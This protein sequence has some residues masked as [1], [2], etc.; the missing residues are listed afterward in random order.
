MFGTRLNYD[1]HFFVDGEEISGVNSVDIGYRNSANLSKPLGYLGG[2]TTVGGPTEQS[3]SVSRYLISD[4]TI[5]D[6]TIGQ[7]A[8]GSL[9]YNNSSYGFTNGY[10]TNYSVNVAVG[11]IPQVNYNFVIYDELRSGANASGT[12]T[13]NIDIPTQ[14]SITA[15]CNNSTTNRVLGFDYS[16]TY[17]IKPYY[18]IG[19][20][21]P[22]EVKAIHPTAYTAS[23]QL[24]VDDA[25]PES[26]Y[27][28]L[29]SGKDGRGGKFGNS[30]VV[31]LTV[32]GRDGST[33]QTYRLPSAV[34]VSEELSSS[35]DGSL[36]LN[37]NYIGNQ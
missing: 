21:S 10:L 33:I 32:K 5:E 28:F 23:I 24:D 9:N 14:G 30:D 25:M 34:L 4:T 22:S 29:T 27:N 15:T 17:T 13:S 18:T 35:A 26:G 3:L 11:A 2:V 19:S 36:R 12:T 6:L 8:S 7:R 20:Q 1:S 37:L 31:V 16:K